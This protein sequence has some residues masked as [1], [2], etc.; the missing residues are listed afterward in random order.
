MSAYVLA[1]VLPSAQQRYGEILAL[2]AEGAE[3]DEGA[4]GAGKRYG[5]AALHD[6]LVSL[7]ADELR[8]AMAPADVTRV[9]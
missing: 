1:R 4:E 5:L 3:E 8:E 6:L 2:L 7:G 9:Y